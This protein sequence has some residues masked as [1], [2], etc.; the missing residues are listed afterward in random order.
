MAQISVIKK[1]ELEGAT[2]LDAEYYQP[3][4]LATAKALGGHP[5][6][7][8]FLQRSIIH[9][10]E[11]KR[12]Y[13][14]RGYPFALSQNIGDN[15]L[16]FS[17]QVFIPHE[18]AKLVSKNKVEVGDIL[19]IRT[20][21]VGKAAPY[22]GEPSNL[23]ASAHVL[24]VKTKDI[25]PGYLST[26][27]NSKFGR[28]L[29]ERGTYGA[30]QPE[31]APSY[32]ET[33]PVP[34]LGDSVERAIESMV[35]E[36]YK[37]RKQS[38]SLY[39]QA[40]QLLLDE[41][42][43]KDLGLS[44][45]LY[46]TVPLKKTKEAGRLDA[47]HFQPKYRRLEERLLGYKGGAKVLGN[48]IQPITNGYDCREFVSDGVPYLRVGDVRVGWLDLS[49]AERISPHFIKKDIALSV[50]DVL[51]TRKGTYGVA[52]QVKLGEEGC[53]ISSEIMRLR[54]LPGSQVL[55]DY[56]ALFLNSAAA[57][58]QVE[59]YIHG[60]SNFSITQTDIQKLI[61]PLSARPF[62]LKVA[63]LVTQSWEAR[64]K[65]RQLLEEAKHKVETIIEGKSS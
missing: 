43:F 41:I 53:I 18:N 10:T 62:Q 20:G 16:D 57:R 48:L 13:E 8:Q 33:V 61:M 50:G 29:L 9:P 12:V 2:R 60:F 63:D 37:V 58:M 56:L 27:L 4:Y 21:Q 38:E 25:S 14:D 49:S 34:R 11:I 47:E 1:S 36:A 3:K 32:V 7:K 44:H 30:L 45:Q 31:L 23:Y 42:G 19:M 64:Q 15:W 54:L 28:T 26:Y 59:K 35:L 22:L 46:Y 17:Q 5:R 51:F 40:E 52:S 55:P 6:L 39:L 65:A 24:I